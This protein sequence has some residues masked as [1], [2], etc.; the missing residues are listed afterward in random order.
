MIDDFLIFINVATDRFGLLCISFL[1]ST[2]SF[3]SRAETIRI[4]I[5]IDALCTFR[6]ERICQLLRSYR[7][8]VLVVFQRENIYVLP[9]KN[10]LLR[11]DDLVRNCLSFTGYLLAGFCE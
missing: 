3:G 1:A 4:I 9:K 5:E 10:P 8:M 6:S 7:R 11:M 2:L